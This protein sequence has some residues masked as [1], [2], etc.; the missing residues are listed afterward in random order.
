MFAFRSEV[1]RIDWEMKS[2]GGI[3]KFWE[4]SPFPRGRKWSTSTGAMVH[5]RI[6]PLLAR[7]IVNRVWQFHFGAGLV[8]SSSDF[9]VRGERPS[10]PELLDDLTATFVR[11]GWSLKSLHKL[12]LLSRTYQL[13]S[14]D[15]AE[16][17]NLD[18]ENRWLWR[19]PR[20]SLDAESIRDSM[21][22]ERTLIP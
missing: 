17:L 4:V 7:V 1:N 19:F 12:L 3:S 11:D 20:L 18:A 8:R 9:G 10:H 13:A 22:A 15:D 5:G 14:T 2:R 16:N 6:K 21:P